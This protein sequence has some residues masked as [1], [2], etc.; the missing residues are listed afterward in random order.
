[1]YTNYLAVVGRRTC[2]AMCVRFGFFLFSVKKGEICFGL[3]YLSQ[4]LAILLSV[5]STNVRLIE[6][7][8]S[9]D[10]IRHVLVRTEGNV[11]G[12]PE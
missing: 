7:S 10:L 4:S 6:C 1:M 2:R 3:E 8:V 12:Y 5:L 11:Y 9:S